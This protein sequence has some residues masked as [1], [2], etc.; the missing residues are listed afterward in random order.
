MTGSTGK[1]PD[2]PEDPKTKNESINEDTN[3]KCEA[4]AEG[5]DFIFRYHGEVGQEGLSNRP[6]GTEGRMGET[7]GGARGNS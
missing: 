7:D 5:S 2:E 3:A 1:N 6:G 4:Q